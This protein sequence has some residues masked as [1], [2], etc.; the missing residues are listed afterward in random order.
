MPTEAAV[1]RNDNSTKKSMGIDD[2]GQ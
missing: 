2:Q 1:A